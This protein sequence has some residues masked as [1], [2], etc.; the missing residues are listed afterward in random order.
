MLFRMSDAARCRPLPKKE[1]PRR[2]SERPPE[3]HCGF[4]SIDPMARQTPTSSKNVCCGSQHSIDN[5]TFCDYF[6]HV[7]GAHLQ[8]QVACSVPAR[9]RQKGRPEGSE[10]HRVIGFYAVSQRALDAGPAKAPRD[11]IS[12]SGLVSTPRHEGS[13]G[14]RMP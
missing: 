5:S 10:S 6:L 11:A 13:D 1:G 4:I 12:P 9:T 8:C 7:S 2:I 3:A 14:V